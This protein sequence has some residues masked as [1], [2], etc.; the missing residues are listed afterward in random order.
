MTIADLLRE[1]QR[2]QAL[3]PTR[4]PDALPEGFRRR[5][6]V[7]FIR[8]RIYQL[9]LMLRDPNNPDTLVANAAEIARQSLLPD[10]PRAEA[11]F[12][13]IW[14]QV[15]VDIDH[16]DLAAV[17]KRMITINKLN[18]AIADR[19]IKTREYLVGLIVW[20]LGGEDSA[21]LDPANLTRLHRLVDRRLRTVE[22]MLYDVGRVGRERWWKKMGPINANPKGPWL[23]GWNRAFEYPRVPRHKEISRDKVVPLFEPLCQPEPGEVACRG[24]GLEGWKIRS[25]ENLARDIKVND[26]SIDMRNPENNDWV[27]VGPNQLYLRDNADPVA[28]LFR[29]FEPAPDYKARCLLYCDHVIHLLHL[30]ALTLSRTKRAEDTSFLDPPPGT[31][32]PPSGEPIGWVRI[33]SDAVEDTFLGSLGR[34]P[35]YFSLQRLHRAQLQIGDHIIIYAHPAYDNAVPDGYWK[36]E[37]ALVVRLG[38]RFLVQ[39]HGVDPSFPDHPKSV[40]PRVSPSGS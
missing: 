15:L 33:V 34:P 23:D 37:N 2:D 11:A 7:I 8:S 21:L 10:V 16:V 9:L 28:A 5:V 25:H 19:P 24:P 1:L 35:E 30:E 14:A 40:T 12:D 4:G 36:L 32:S 3:I 17:D 31:P 13:A 27:P 29:L 22:R 18:G 38:D 26:A 39:G 6:R 20:G